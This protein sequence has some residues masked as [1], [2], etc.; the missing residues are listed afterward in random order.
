MKTPLNQ[1][2]LRQHFTYHWWMY[3]LL[4]VAAIFGTNLVYTVTAYRSPPEKK[5]EFYI[6]GTANTDAIDA[7]MAEV[8]ERDL[9]DMEVMSS[10]MMGIDSTYGP[11]QLSTYMAAGEGDLYLL[12]REEFI[13]YASQGAFLPLEDQTKLMHIF[14]EAS[15]SLQSGWRKETSTGENHLYGIPLSRLAGLQKLAYAKDGFL[16]ILASCGNDM[17]VYR[18]LT[19]LC[20][21]MIQE[22][23]GEEAAG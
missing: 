19:I 5:I 18:F 3:L 21:D 11:M 20:E 7:Y 16:C 22:A 6:Y 14:D 1:D 13:G 17:N 15:L 23:P 10:L 8:R 4:A 2:N 12:P 9:P